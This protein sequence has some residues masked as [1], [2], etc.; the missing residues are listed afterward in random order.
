MNKAT[1]QTVY[2]VFGTGLTI[3]AGESQIS[4]DGGA[5]ANTTNLPA[6]LAT[7]GVYTLALTAAECNA[8]HLMIQIS[9][10]AV[11]ILNQPFETSAEPTGAVVADGSN[12]A[13]TFETDLTSAVNDYWKDALI[14]FTSGALQYQVKRVSAYNGTSKFITANTPFTAAPSGGDLFRLL[15]D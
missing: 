12:T 3:S 7:T 2:L 5:F 13:S 15:I 14:V 1:A 4:K 10:A 11:V 8:N 9:D 6:E